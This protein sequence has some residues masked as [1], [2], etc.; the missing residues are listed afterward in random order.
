MKIL[1]QLSIALLVSL[2]LKAQWFNLVSGVPDNLYGVSFLNADTGFVCGGNIDHA[3]ILKTVDGGAHWNPVYLDDYAWLYDIVVLNKDTIL[4]TGHGG[5]ILRSTNGGADWHTRPGNTTQWMYKFDFAGTDTGYCVGLNGTVLKT[6][7]AGFT[8]Y[9]K[10]T[11]VTD[12]FLGVDFITAETG[13][14][15]GED[16]QIAR[17]TDGGN[18]WEEI[19]NNDPNFLS[20]VHFANADT[21]F[22]AGFSGTI[23]RTVDGGVS[24]L[25]LPSVTVADLKSVYCKTGSEIYMAGDG[26]IIT[27]TD[28]GDNWTFMNYPVATGLE[29]LCFAAPGVAFAVGKSGTILKAAI[30]VGLDDENDVPAWTVYP[31]PTA[32]H[33]YISGLPSAVSSYLVRDI[34]GRTVQSGTLPVTSAPLDVSTLQNGIYILEIISCGHSAQTRF[35]VSH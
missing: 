11:G 21:G 15:V 28:A 14:A 23:F 24:W 19:E 27:S 16:G 26:V 9:V 25:K 3:L 34:S 18:S 10:N 4:A 32:E 7:D 33:L 1:L 13:V 8:W 20:A 29:A 5:I 12:W 6:T 30:T 2:P 31:N 35:L 22:I 17:T